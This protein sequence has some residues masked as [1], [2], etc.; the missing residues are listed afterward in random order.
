MEKTNDIANAITELF[1]NVD[2]E[3]QDTLETMLHDIITHARKHSTAMG[4]AIKMQELIDEI[5]SN[6]VDIY[7]YDGHD[8]YGIDKAHVDESGDLILE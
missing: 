4:Y 1:L 7:Y 8:Y 3:R 2:P 6:N 5:D